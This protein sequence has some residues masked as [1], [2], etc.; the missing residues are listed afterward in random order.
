MILYAEN[1]TEFTLSIDIWDIEFGERVSSA[2]GLDSEISKDGG[3]FT[4]CVNELVEIGSTGI[5][6]L[7]LTSTE[8]GANKVDL[9]FST[10]T[11]GSKID[12]VHIYTY[13]GSV[14]SSTPVVYW[15]Y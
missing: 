12:T 14:T 7:T 9:K 10:T 3:A 13:S 4:D 2:A 6:E 11:S 5:Y 8:M 1:N 15:R